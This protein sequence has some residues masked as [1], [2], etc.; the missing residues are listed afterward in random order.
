MKIGIC[1]GTIHRALDVKTKN[2]LGGMR[3]LLTDIFKIGGMRN[4]LTDILKT[5]TR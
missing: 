4:L 3:N 5:I 1:A 2:A